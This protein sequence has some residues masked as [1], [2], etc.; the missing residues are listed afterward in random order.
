MVSD[1]YTRTSVCSSVCTLHDSLGYRLGSVRGDDWSSVMDDNSQEYDSGF[2]AGKD[3][4]RRST[5]RLP[6]QKE[7]MDVATVFAEAFDYDFE[8]AWGIVLRA[9]V[10]VFDGYRA[11]SGFTCK[12]A[13]VQYETGAKYFDH[14]QWAGGVCSLIERKK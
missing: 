9:Y 8:E 5:P 10:C 12:I 7:A 4:A 14:Y 6:T 3:F 2:Y 1:G 13:S 11:E